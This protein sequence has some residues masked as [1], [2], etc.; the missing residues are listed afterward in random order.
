MGFAE[1]KLPDL[2]EFLVLEEGNDIGSSGNERSRSIR[3]WMGTMSEVVDHTIGIY[4]KR[5]SL[6]RDGG[7]SVTE[8]FKITL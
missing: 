1:S 5:L 7:N 3:V 4:E 6:S 8:F 2:E